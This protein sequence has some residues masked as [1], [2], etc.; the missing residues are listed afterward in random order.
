MFGAHGGSLVSTR[1]ARGPTSGGALRRLLAPLFDR[2]RI[3][4][5][6]LDT[7][8]KA[9]ADGVVVHVLRSK[10][11]IDPIFLL[12]TLRRVQLA[13]PRF[14]HDHALSER[15]DSV[16]ALIGGLVAGET[17]L[18]NLRRPQTLIGA[19]GGYS[20]PHVEGL[21]AL[22]RELERPILLLPESLL[23]VKRAKGIRRSIFD[24]IF[25]DRE[26]PGRLRETLGFLV[27]ARDARY[28]IGAPVNLQ[29]VLERNKGVPDQVVAKKIRW[30][31]LN[32]LAREDAIRT[33]P[34]Q[35]PT[36]KGPSARSEGPERPA[37][38]R[39]VAGAGR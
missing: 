33:G 38:D 4:P 23:W 10:R 1:A 22:Q 19:S 17:A 24:V 6:A 2:V 12:H 32:H 20:E 11:V 29:A 26:A 31:I 25:G 35:R 28:H 3:E 34:L 8:R 16:A 27:Y 36:N 14:I 39:R 30:S 9:H 21:L 7:L 37:R 5:E 15:D 18:L 13:E